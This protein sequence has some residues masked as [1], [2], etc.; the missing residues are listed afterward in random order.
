M[1]SEPEIDGQLPTQGILLGENEL[2]ATAKAADR[3]I[4]SSDCRNL[5][6]IMFFTVSDPKGS[7]SKVKNIRHSGLL[8][9]VIS[10][11]GDNKIG[12]VDRPYI[13]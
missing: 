8:V 13:A 1:E 12:S 7:L 2:V 6:A 5:D 4:M 11:F 3:I 10:E 9:N